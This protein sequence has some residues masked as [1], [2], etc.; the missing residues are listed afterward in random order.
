MAGSP[1]RHEWRLLLTF[2]LE[3]LPIDPSPPEV[4]PVTRYVK[5]APGAGTSVSVVLL[6]RESRDEI[7]NVP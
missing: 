2:P 6:D 5:H 1:R 3:S 4:F 7:Q